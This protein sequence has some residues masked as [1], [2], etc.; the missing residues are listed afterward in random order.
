MYIYVYI[1]THLY[2][3][4]KPV[5]FYYFLFYTVFQCSKSMFSSTINSQFTYFLQSPPSVVAPG[6]GPT[7]VKM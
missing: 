7:R 1:Y 6:H 5:F 4:T 3:C 2:V